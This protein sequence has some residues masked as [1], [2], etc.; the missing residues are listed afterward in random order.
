MSDELCS[1]Y[2]HGY[3]ENDRNGPYEIISGQYLTAVAPGALINTNG[4]FGDTLFLKYTYIEVP[5]QLITPISTS[6][7]Q[8]LFTTLPQFRFGTLID[9]GST[10]NNTPPN[11]GFRVDITPSNI[12]IYLND[13]NTNIVDF[14]HN[15]DFRF[16]HRFSIL[17]ADGTISVF[18]DN[19]IVGVHDVQSVGN[20]LFSQSYKNIISGR[21]W[22]HRGVCNIRQKGR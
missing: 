4:T 18:C 3:G 11:Y 19:E 17:R 1:M 16:T 20:V 6:E 10:S 21:N 14:P 13:G 12:S 5:A 22:R 2:I 9:F 7:F 8:I 15:I